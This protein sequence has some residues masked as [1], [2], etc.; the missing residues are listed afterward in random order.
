MYILCFLRAISYDIA[1]KRRIFSS[2]AKPEDKKSE[3]EGLYCGILPD[4]SPY[5]YNMYS[6]LQRS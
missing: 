2:E 3:V 1:P 5:T 4:R 6:I